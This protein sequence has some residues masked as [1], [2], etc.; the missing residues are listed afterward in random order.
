MAWKSWWKGM[1]PDA[2]KTDALAWPLPRIEFMSANSISVACTGPTGL[3][4]VVVALAWWGLHVQGEGQTDE[5]LVAVDDVLWVLTQIAG[6]PKPKVKRDTD[7]E[8]EEP[9]NKK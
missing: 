3:L 2:R 8:D 9:K 1:Q 6:L 5:F 7:H 4:L